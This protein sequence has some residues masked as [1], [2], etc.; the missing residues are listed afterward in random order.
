LAIG[1]LNYLAHA[2]RPDIAFSTNVL[3][4]HLNAYGREHW[5]AVKHL[6]WYLC[7][8]KDMCIRYSP[9]DH[10]T[11]PRG[12]SN[13]NWASDQTTC[14]STSSVLFTLTSGP[15]YWSSKN[16]KS[17]ATSTTEAKLHAL[18]ETIKHTIFLRNF[19]H[20]LRLT[21]HKRIPIFC[22]NQS[23]LT[24]T[25]SKPG[26]HHQCSKHYSVKLT[27]AHEN[28]AKNVVS[29]HYLLTK[30]MPAD[31]LTKALSKGRIIELSEILNLDH[32]PLALKGRVVS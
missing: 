23:T 22:N 29:L 18:A 3:S 20:N 7:S 13:A 24:I 27:L 15:I 4:R 11:T 19:Y 16:Q 5:A 6:L 28:L 10:D 30:S 26:E 17:I 2:L 8:T 9:D 12:F 1:R 32:S 31:L 21:Q 14:K 25:N